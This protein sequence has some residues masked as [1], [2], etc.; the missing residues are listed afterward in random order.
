MGDEELRELVL[1]RLA[2]REPGQVAEARTT[3]KA[4]VRRSRGRRSAQLRLLWELNARAEREAG[5]LDLGADGTPLL[6]ALA[7][8]FGSGVTRDPCYPCLGRALRGPGCGPVPRHTV[9]R[10][11]R[12]G[13][14]ARLILVHPAPRTE[15]DAQG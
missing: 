9:R 13:S 4:P 8:A 2:R 14:C 10:C 15:H 12:V 11:P 3:S 5:E 7:R 1:A 6:A